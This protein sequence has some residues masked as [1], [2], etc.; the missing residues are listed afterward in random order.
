MAELL[1]VSQSSLVLLRPKLGLPSPVSALQSTNTISYQRLSISPRRIAT[2]IAVV[3]SD[4]KSPTITA[5]TTDSTKQE[6]E[7][8]Y[9]GFGGGGENLGGG[10]GGGGGGGDDNKNEGGGESEE[11]SGKKKNAGMSMSQKLTLGYAALVG[12]TLHLINE[13]I[14]IFHFIDVHEFLVLHDRD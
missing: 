8:D 12:G 5:N 6:I 14:T 9:G 13:I 1:G 7:I 10:G 11:E 3:S 2:S 4:S